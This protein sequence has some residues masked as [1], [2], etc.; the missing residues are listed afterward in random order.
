MYPHG[1]AAGRQRV[2]NPFVKSR[3]RATPLSRRSRWRNRTRPVLRWNRSFPSRRLLR[4]RELRKF[5][6]NLASNRGPTALSQLELP[7]SEM[8]DQPLASE[9]YAPP[10]R[11]IR[12]VLITKITSMT[13]RNDTRWNKVNLVRRFIRR[14]QNPALRFGLTCTINRR[15]NLL[16][17]SQNLFSTSSVAIGIPR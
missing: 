5:L 13:R 17:C 11:S 14:R 1:R 8:D 16:A 12:G 6:L 9:I 4:S 2:H 15:S 3:R 7:P 10:N